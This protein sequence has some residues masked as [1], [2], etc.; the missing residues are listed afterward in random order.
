MV[1]Q[2]GMGRW[3]WGRWRVAWVGI[4]VLSCGRASS[5]QDTVWGARRAP[6]RWPAP[7]SGRPLVPGP[8][9]IRTTAAL[10]GGQG[11]EY[12]TD[13][14][15]LASDGIKA[16]ASQTKMFTGIRERRERSA[17]SFFDTMG[18]SP[19][20]KSR[21]VFYVYIVS[22]STG[23]TASHALTSCMTQFEDIAVDW[24]ETA[25]DQGGDP[26][27]DAGR[28]EVRTQMFSNVNEWGRL[29]RIVQLASK[30][31]AFIVFTLVD[32]QLNARMVDKCQTL[33]IQHEDLLGPLVCTI[34]EYL[35][36][37]PSGRP[38]SSTQE[39]RRPLSDKYFQR[40]AAVEFTIKHD[41]G[42]LPENYQNADVVL[43]GVSR[44][45]KTPLSTYLA[46]QFGYKMG[47]VPVI[48]DM[49]IDKSIVNNVDPRKVFG[50]T[51]SPA[52]LKRIRSR[53]LAA[54]GVDKSTIG[55]KDGSADYDSLQFIASEVA[56][57]LKLYDENP[58]WSVL[59]VTGRSVEENSA[60]ITELLSHPGKLT[61]VEQ[62]L[63]KARENFFLAV[64]TNPQT[65]VT[66]AALPR[67]LASDALL[68]AARCSRSDISTLGKGENFV[69]K[70]L[71]AAD[72]TEVECVREAVKH[73]SQ[74]WSK[75]T[76]RLSAATNGV[77]AI[78]RTTPL[79]D[80]SGA[81]AYVICTVAALG[82][83]RHQTSS[84]AAAEASADAARLSLTS[85]LGYVEDGDALLQQVVDSKKRL[86]VEDDKVA[87]RISE[88]VL[89]VGGEFVV[90]LCSDK[91]AQ[92]A[93]R[94]TS[95]I[96]GSPLSL[97]YGQNTDQYT[98]DMIRSCLDR[99]D[100]VSTALVL[101]D[102]AGV[103]SWRHLYLEPVYSEQGLQ[104][105]LYVGVQLQ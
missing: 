17:Q 26:P 20:V 94:T 15:N 92:S 45:G 54:T 60:I 14:A 74:G 9:Q 39:R 52:Y 4:V 88:F 24:H 46:Q 58:Q 40:I 103:P 49:P 85:D 1:K 36:L 18:P 73:G 83:Q 76:A 29:D 59:D 13:G 77:E 96:V 23:F 53:R 44:T 47:N 3:R 62:A 71:S 10:R 70:L 81:V 5:V 25:D 56:W 75:I 95:E 68:A 42:N 34:S 38:K 6:S 64:V 27:E 104:P 51:M 79:Y 48:K 65:G 33:N 97:F 99:G 84:P 41:D 8:K 89:D 55:V 19:R 7:C 80:D 101:Y 30:M 105:V 90:R 11:N 63:L 78:A 87:A 102:K 16:M 69:A 21:P 91:F 43:L 28:M 35:S 66:P 72:E 50:L 93:G 12:T 37:K 22:D 67:I 98:I 2:S 31:N 61:P 57:G 32:P 100:P 86:F 82:N